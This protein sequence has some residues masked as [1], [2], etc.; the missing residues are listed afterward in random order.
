MLGGEF[1]KVNTEIQKYRERETT[2]IGGSYWKL[3]KA[4]A[5]VSGELIRVLC[6]GTC[7]HTSG[8]AGDEV[9]MHCTVQVPSAPVQ[10]PPLD[11]CGPPIIRKRTT[12]CSDV[13]SGTGEGGRLLVSV[14]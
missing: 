7:K 10:L 9:L 5:R 12:W 1:A 8:T 14:S 11:L 2:V 4:I 13:R 6:G 3:L